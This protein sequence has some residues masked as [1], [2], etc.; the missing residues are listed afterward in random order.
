MIDLQ[1]IRPEIQQRPLRGALPIRGPRLD[2]GFRDLQ[3]L[4]NLRVALHLM[5]QIIRSV[6]I[7]PSRLAAPNQNRR[8]GNQ[9]RPGSAQ[10]AIAGV[11]LDRVIRSEPVREGEVSA[12]RAEFYQRLRETR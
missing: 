7:K 10:V 8:S 4:A 5:T 6:E 11:Q 12:G 3:Q 1:R 2:L 9:Q